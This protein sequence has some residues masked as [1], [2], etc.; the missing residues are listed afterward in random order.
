LQIDVDLLASRGELGQVE[1]ADGVAHGCLRRPEHRLGVVLHFQAGLLRIPYHPENSRVDVDG[2]Q[3]AGERRLGGEGHDADALVDARR[4]VVG[5]GDE[6]VDARSCDAVK[7]TEAQD[8]HVLPFG[9]QADT[10]GQRCADDHA[11]DYAEGA[12]ERISQHACD[13]ETRTE[14]PEGEQVDAQAPGFARL[15]SLDGRFLLR[16]FV[17]PVLVLA[18]EAA[19]SKMGCLR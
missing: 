17:R 1:L 12:D 14:Q 4:G 9:G 10:G 16:T 15:E 13:D 18:H 19:L 3:V 6:E 8:D 11:D 7:A 5:E 2:H